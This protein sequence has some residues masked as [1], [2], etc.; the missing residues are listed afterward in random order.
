MI[1]KFQDSQNYK[2]RK[3][4]VSKQTN[5]GSIVLAKLKKKIQNE[6]RKEKRKW[7][8]ERKRWMLDI[9]VEYLKY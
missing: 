8:V 7:E 2:E 3:E 4:T 6:K 9:L 5:A 1:Y